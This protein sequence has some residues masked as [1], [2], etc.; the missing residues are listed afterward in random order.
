M[1][2]AGPIS[3]ALMAITELKNM[4]LETFLFY[5]KGNSVVVGV[6]TESEET[7]ILTFMGGHRQSIQ[8]CVQ[9]NY[10]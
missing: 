6:L 5:V 8:P 9:A 7:K 10:M 4:S 3:W 2:G 1:N